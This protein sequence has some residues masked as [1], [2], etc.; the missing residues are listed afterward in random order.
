[1]ADPADRIIALHSGMSPA[2]VRGRHVMVMQAFIDDSR[3]DGRVLIL[4]GYIASSEKWAS[5][6]REWQSRLDMRPKWRSFKMS[7]IGQSSDPERW[8]RAGFFYRV[9]EEH[10]KAFVALAVDIEA[11]NRVVDEL[12]LPDRLRNPYIVGFRA[13]IDFIAQ[14]QVELGIDE[15]I[16]LIFDERGEKQSVRDGFAVF[17]ENCPPE[18]RSRLGREPRFETD[19]DFNPLQ[20]ADMLAWLVRRHWLD[21][22]SITSEFVH[23]PWKVN[24]DIPGYKFEM[25]YD[26]LRV[27]MLAYRQRLIDEGYQYVPAGT[28]VTVK[29]TVKFSYDPPETD[30]QNPPV[31]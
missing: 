27:N 28:T 30:A 14:Y 22:G 13:L 12:R 25:D 18:I 24:R 29:V 5:F 11:L 26:N 15:P 20:A 21:K 6:A 2:R 23:V 31:A 8:E 7:K 17:A 9:I 10:C 4:A 19:D 16:D 3:T 1:M